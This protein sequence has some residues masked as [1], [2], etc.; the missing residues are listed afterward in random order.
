MLSSNFNVLI[1]YGGSNSSSIISRPLQQAKKRKQEFNSILNKL[2]LKNVTFI[3]K[4]AWLGEDMTVQVGAL[5]L[6]AK[7]LNLS[8]NK[9]EINSLIIKDPVF[10]IRNYSKLKPRDSL[11]TNNDNEST[12][13]ASLE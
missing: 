3:K 6:D 10:A 5:N 2:E 7:D 4:D 1:L 11:A 8:G 13:P 9:Y 12:K